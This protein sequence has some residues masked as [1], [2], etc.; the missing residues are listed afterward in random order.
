[1]MTDDS[2]VADG[3]SNFTADCFSAGLAWE[4]EAQQAMLM[5]INTENKRGK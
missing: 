2:L 1:M 5:W 4:Q 3:S